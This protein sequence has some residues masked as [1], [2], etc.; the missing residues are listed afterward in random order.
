MENN[1]DKENEQIEP[2][3]E[4]I[5]E[6]VAESSAEEVTVGEAT[7]EE[8][9]LT[10]ENEETKTAPISETT[11]S[12]A[13]VAK[14]PFPAWIL[15]VLGVLLV[16]VITLLVLIIPREIDYTVSVVDEIGNPVSNVMVKLTDITGETKTR[17]TDKMGKV[18]FNDIKVKIIGKKNVVN[19]IQGLSKAK[20]LTAEYQ[21][22]KWSTELRAVVC[23]EENIL[24]ITG[25]IEEDSYAYF[26]KPAS[27]NI[28]SLNGAVYF[29]FTA[30]E[31]GV[32]SVSIQS[33]DTAAT[34][35]YVGMPMY[36]QTT[37]VGDGEYD[38]KSFELIIQD[39]ETPYV[40]AVS[41]SS[42]SDVSF[43]IERTADAP[44]D[45]QYMPWT[46][47]PTTEN[48]IE[49][50]TNV[51]TPLD[52]AN[53]SLS[54]ELR[55]GYYYTSTGKRIYV[56]IGSSSEYLDASLALLAGCIDDKVGINIGGYVYENGVFKDKYS[57]NNMIEDY[58]NHCDENGVY[59]LTEELAE[60]IKLHGESSGWWNPTSPNFLFAGKPY[61]AD[62]AWLF[63]CCTSN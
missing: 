31:K 47:V 32:Y 51:L 30:N 54:V 34:V 17:V 61:N 8:E 38:G 53:A 21:L 7:A 4:P 62:N 52:I 36:V 45:P 50:N 58:Y 15:A 9:T 40:I 63:L 56:R 55:D 22:D 39:I 2:I 14:K 26:A 16:S 29:C 5:E 10:H 44:L 28:P 12:S 48:F 19:L 25:Q 41:A 20:I 35:A 3:I 46:S 37:H 33:D 60:G 11:V 1:F 24:S 13:P 42:G 49:V 23:N 18:T 43:T 27:Y 59:P 6:P 57:Y